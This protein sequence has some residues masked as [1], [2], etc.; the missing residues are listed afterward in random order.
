MASNLSRWSVAA[1][2][3]ALSPLLSTQSSR[4]LEAPRAAKSAY[5]K[6]AHSHPPLQTPGSPRLVTGLM[7]TCKYGRWPKYRWG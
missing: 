7:H 1:R 4:H 2:R 5:L 6:L 3:V